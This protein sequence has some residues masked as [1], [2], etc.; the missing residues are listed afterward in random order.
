[1]LASTSPRALLMHR[2]AVLRLRRIRCCAPRVLGSL[3]ALPPAFVD[4][5][6]GVG[7]G[8]PPVQQEGLDLGAI[9]VHERM[10]PGLALGMRDDVVAEARIAC[11]PTHHGTWLA[12]AP[13]TLGGA[14]RLD[15]NPSVEQ[16]IPIGNPV[17][18]AHLPPGSDLSQAAEADDGSSVGMAENVTY[19]PASG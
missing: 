3:I 10:Q 8:Q 15:Q 13:V 6:D 17:L 18:S 11:D 9:S 19:I 1:M 7:V 14:Q 2:A 16:R 12:P 5:A 4:G